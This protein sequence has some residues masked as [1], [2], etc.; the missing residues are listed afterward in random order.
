MLKARE[1]TSPFSL[2]RNQFVQ[3]IVFDPEQGKLTLTSRV[4]SVS[5]DSLVLVWPESPLKGRYFFPG[6][7]FAVFQAIVRGKVISFK[8]DI[9]PAILQQH[10]DRRL[11]INLPRFWEKMEQKRRFIR[12]KKQME[13][14]FRLLCED[15]F[16]E[17]FY[18]GESIDIS[19]GGIEISSMELMEPGDVLE[20]FFSMEF[21]DFHGV[22]ARVLRRSTEA[23]NENLTY[24]YS[25]EFTGMFEREKDTL[26]QLLMRSM[27]QL[28]K[29]KIQPVV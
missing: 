24:R 16:S 12:V 25:L 21:F 6:V 27:H 28:P 29:P 1:A 20:L 14:K 7:R 3:L 5:G 15:G 9:T 2:V 17:S 10:E 8:V 19:V 13:M 22:L 4:V 23:G 26:N 11:T 18:S